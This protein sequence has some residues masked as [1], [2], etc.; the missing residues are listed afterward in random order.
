MTE[1][2]AANTFI[3]EKHATLQNARIIAQ[4]IWI[5]DHVIKKSRGEF[6]FILTS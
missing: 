2:A 4:V 6:S 3:Q 1:L 5:K